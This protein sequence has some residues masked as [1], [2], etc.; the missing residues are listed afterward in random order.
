MKKND[1]VVV[2]VLTLAVLG[3]AAT[4]RAQQPS[5]AEVARQTADARKAKEKDKASKTYTNADLKGGRALT[6]TGAAPAQAEAKGEAAAVAAAP[7]AGDETA[8]RV[9]ELRAYVGERQE[10]ARRLEQRIRELNDAVLN[11]FSEQQREQLVRERDA[12]IG[13]IRK[14]QLEVAAQTKAADDLEAAAKSPA[15]APQKPQ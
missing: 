5:L 13:D 1:R 4:A 9:Q 3:F 10:E 12:V 15:S 8:K 7:A 11:T 14:V 6:V 2:T